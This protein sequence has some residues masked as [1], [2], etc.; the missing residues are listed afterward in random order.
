MTRAVGC[1]DLLQFTV[2]VA[3]DSLS[4]RGAAKLLT[5][6]NWVCYGVFSS[7]GF[8]RSIGPSPHALSFLHQNPDQHL[9]AFK[10]FPV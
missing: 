6:R 7:S 3:V 5:V 2:L 10:A 9:A 1:F 4:C 8:A